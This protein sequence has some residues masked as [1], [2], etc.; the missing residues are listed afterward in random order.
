V[1]TW[2]FRLYR[3]D[4]A[5]PFHSTYHD[6]RGRTDE[7]GLSLELAVALRVAT[8]DE[9]VDRIELVRQVSR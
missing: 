5:E 1:T 7:A 8:A 2:A 9:R 4:E 3:K 6:E